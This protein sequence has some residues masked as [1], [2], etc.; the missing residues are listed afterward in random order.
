[1]GSDLQPG[2]EI[3]WGKRS[4]IEVFRTNKNKQNKRGTEKV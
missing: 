4:M 2:K 1:M 3:N